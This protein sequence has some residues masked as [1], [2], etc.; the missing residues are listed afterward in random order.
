MFTNIKSKSKNAEED[1]A[2]FKL[3]RRQKG[4]GCIKKETLEKQIQQVEQ[5]HKDFP[6]IRFYDFHK[7]A[8]KY[9]N[10]ALFGYKEDYYKGEFLPDGY[11]FHYNAIF[12][13][14]IVDYSR[15]SK[16]KISRIIDWWFMYDGEEC[17]PIY[18]MEFARGGKYVRDVWAEPIA[19]KNGK[20]ALE[21][22]MNLMCEICNK[23]PQMIIINRSSE[24]RKKICY[25][26][27]E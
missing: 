20:T 10:E 23:N 5:V 2:K 1:I 11:F 14:E 12:L 19:K 21:E 3:I 8:K 13:I 9:Y 4:N 6:K 25:K 27:N 17:Q 7:Y 18:L 22:C 15:L 16:E 26:C 24:N